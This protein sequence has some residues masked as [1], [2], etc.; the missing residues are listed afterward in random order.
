MFI[1]PAALK[2]SPGD[3]PPTEIIGN[4]I[5]N[6]FSPYDPIAR[7]PEAS[8]AA[9]KTTVQ[10]GVSVLT[11][12]GS[13]HNKTRIVA[14]ISQE[15]KKDFDGLKTH[16][17]RITTL[18]RNPG[19]EEIKGLVRATPSAKQ[20]LENW[21]DFS[22]RGSAGKLF[23]VAAVMYGDAHTAR[24]TGDNDRVQVVVYKVLRI[25]TR[26]LEKKKMTA[27]SGSKCY[28]VNA[29]LGDEEEEEDDDIDTG[30]LRVVDLAEKDGG[31]EAF[32]LYEFVPVS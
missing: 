3:P 30:E 21:R 16:D 14:R 5:T 13:H 10:Q 2:P 1:L 6:P 19:D 11:S 20:A 25:S 12:S 7:L 4:L 18:E 9:V 29:M 24:D 32:L 28:R 8:R 23:L 31:E 17:L 22:G 26:G 27:S 15:A